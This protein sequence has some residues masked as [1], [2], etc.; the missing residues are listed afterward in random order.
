MIAIEPSDFFN[1][2]K[3]IFAVYFIGLLVYLSLRNW[4]YRWKGINSKQLF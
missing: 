3:I 2:N 1:W 4:Y